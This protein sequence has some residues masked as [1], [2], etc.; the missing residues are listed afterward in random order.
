MSN[1]SKSLERIVF[2]AHTQKWI[3][4]FILMDLKDNPKN[5]KYIYATMGKDVRG[6]SNVKYVLLDIPYF[7]GSK[8]D[9][10]DIL[11]FLE[12][13]GIKPVSQSDYLTVTK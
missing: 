3:C 7:E 1:E 5:K 9:L 10:N 8:N 12:S 11:Y 2:I 13:R 4:N 6:L